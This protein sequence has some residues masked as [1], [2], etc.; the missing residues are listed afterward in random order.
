AQIIVGEWVKHYN[1]VRPHSALG[2]RP[3][4]PQAQ[5]PQMIQNQPILLQ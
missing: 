2:Y 5:V 4:A 3:P 1:Q